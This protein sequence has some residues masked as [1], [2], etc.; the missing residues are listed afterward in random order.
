MPPTQTL[1]PEH[2]ARQAPQF[3]RVPS[4]VSHP[5]R[6]SPSQSAKPA[7]Q[8]RIAHLLGAAHSADATFE[9]VA[10][11]P[12]QRSGTSG[13]ASAAS[14]AASLPASTGGAT[15]THR[16][17]AHTPPSQSLPHALQLAPSL[18]RSTQRPSHAVYPVTHRQAAPM[19]SAWAPQVFAS[20]AT[21]A[22]GAGASV[23]ASTATLA[24]GV[25]AASAEASTVGAASAGVSSTEGAQPMNTAKTT[26]RAAMRRMGTSYA[27]PQLAVDPG[28]VAT[29]E[30]P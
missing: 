7:A 18:Y 23:E 15:L 17:S 25:S 4:I 22:G 14:G 6:S 8:R 3:S 30:H 20:A 16:P 28:H 13:A 26:K 29:T 1:A 10:H 2:T 24:S 9:S 12:P 27:A 11:D 19:R 5:L 21:S